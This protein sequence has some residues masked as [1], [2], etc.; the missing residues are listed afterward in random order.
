MDRV[1]AYGVQEAMT[2]FKILRLFSFSDTFDNVACCMD[3]VPAYG[4]Q[5]AMTNFK[6]LRLF[7]FSDTFDII[8]NLYF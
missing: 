3:R 8:I 4:V 6:I 1:P 5:E 2:N 7:S